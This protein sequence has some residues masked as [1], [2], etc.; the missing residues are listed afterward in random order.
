MLAMIAYANLEREKMM[1]YAL[2]AAAAMTGFA[3]LVAEATILSVPMVVPEETVYFNEAGEA[4]TIYVPMGGL[5]MI[6]YAKE[7]A[8]VVTD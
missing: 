3:N 1:Y 5:V 6:A 4:E 7:V 8:V 2:L